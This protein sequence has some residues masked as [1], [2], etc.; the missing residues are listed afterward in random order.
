M[1]ADASGAAV[2]AAAAAAAA[3][4]S[5]PE[6]IATQ[7]KEAPVEPAENQL[8]WLSRAVN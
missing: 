8:I 4:Q 2:A 7:S 3:D 1:R 6:Y 5:E